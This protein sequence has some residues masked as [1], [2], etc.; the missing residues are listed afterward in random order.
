MLKLL[1]VIILNAIISLI[2]VEHRIQRL[3][4]YIRMSALQDGIINGVAV[5]KNDYIRDEALYIKKREARD[6]AV[7]R[8]IGRLDAFMAKEKRLIPEPK[9]RK[10][11]LPEGVEA[12]D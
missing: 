8:Y 5:Y 1:Y 4:P 11:H 12:E 2:I 10:N 6:E 3:R 9:I 7:R